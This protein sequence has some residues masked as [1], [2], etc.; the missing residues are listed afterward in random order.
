M[1]KEERLLHD[2]RASSFPAQDE[3][4]RQAIF[5]LVRN[6]QDSWWYLEW[7]GGRKKAPVI[8]VDRQSS[9]ADQSEYRARC[10]FVN[11][12][13]AHFHFSGFDREAVSVIAG[14]GATPLSSD[15]LGSEE[16]AGPTDGRE[17]GCCPQS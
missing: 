10:G 6:Y 9:A 4:A 15:P 7:P 1:A 2:G 16:E 8:L 3:D 17:E 13:K 14:A 5:R 12:D 11:P